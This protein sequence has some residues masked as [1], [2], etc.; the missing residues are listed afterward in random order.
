MIPIGSKA[1]NRI[2]PKGPQIRT[3][4]PR[5]PIVTCPLFENGI[6]QFHWLEIK[7]GLLGGG[8]GLEISGKKV[9]H[10]LLLG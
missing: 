5:K 9:A 4:H 2:S 7:G 1:T 10:D 6:L 8:E 3:Q